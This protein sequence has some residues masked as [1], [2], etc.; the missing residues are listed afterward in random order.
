MDGITV[1]IING[2]DIRVYTIEDI[3]PD[4]HN[5]QRVIDEE[6]DS[7]RWTEMLFSGDLVAYEVDGSILV[8]I[9]VDI[10]P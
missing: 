8:I 5:P 2:N 10:V 9:P 4:T 7:R 1:N 3:I 6:E